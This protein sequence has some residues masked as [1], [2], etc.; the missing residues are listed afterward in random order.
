M[1]AS[2]AEINTLCAGEA[3]RAFAT[4]RMAMLEL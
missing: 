3:R 2:L 4:S 1:A